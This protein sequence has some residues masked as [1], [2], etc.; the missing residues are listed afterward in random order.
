VSFYWKKRGFVFGY[1]CYGYDR[2]GLEGL[3]VFKRDLKFDPENYMITV[4][5]P[6][7]EA[8]ISVFDKVVVKIEVEKDKNTQRGK[9]KMTLV[10]PINSNGL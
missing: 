8:K 10:S 9:V 1:L 5:G 6:S 3:V 7:G 2:L 4:P